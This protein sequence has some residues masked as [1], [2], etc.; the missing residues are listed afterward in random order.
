MISGG[1]MSRVHLLDDGSSL[2]WVDKETLKYT[3]GRFTVLIWVDFEAG[4]F[5]GGRIIKYS[6]LASW[7]TKPEGCSS[8][9]EEKK[10]REILMKVQQ[11]YRS[12]NKECRV[13]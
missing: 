8:A 1:I 2:E 6:S 7:N 10:K 11:Y 3:E 12:Q 9:I 5:S 4:F 13:E